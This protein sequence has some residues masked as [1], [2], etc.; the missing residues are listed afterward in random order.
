VKPKLVIAI[1]IDQFR[2]D[3]LTRFRADYHNGIDQLLT[4]G[5][6]FTSAYYGQVPT[7]TAVG[8]SIFMS[9]AMPAVSG[10]VGNSWYD[11]ETHQIVTS[12]CDWNMKVVGAPQAEKKSGCTD[13]DP[14]SPARLLVST[15][16]DELRLAHP[17]AKVIGISRKARAAILPSGHAANGAFWFDDG[18]GNFITSSFYMDKLPP[19]VEAFNARKLPEK[20]VDRPWPNFPNW[21]FRAGS[22]SKA[23]YS[24][25]DASPWSNELIEA[26]AEQAITGEK[27]GQRGETDLLTVSFSANDA[28]GHSVGPYAPEVKDMAIR[29]DQLIGKLFALLEQK[30]GMQNVI[31]VLSADHGVAPTPQQNAVDKIPGGYLTG[32]VETTITKALSE[33]FGNQRWLLNGSSESVYF[34]NDAIRNPKVRREDV[35]ETARDAL[36]NNPELHIVRVYS[37]SQLEN[38]VAGDFIAQAEMNGFFPRRSGDLFLVFDPGYMAGAH[39]TSHFSP[40][41]YDRHVP[42]VFMGPVIRAGRYSADARP[43]DIAP[44]LADI[45]DLQVPSG[46]SGRVLTEMLQREK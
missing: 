14:A 20:Y 25:L 39:G 21:K 8:H 31:V 13:D 36:L 34:N 18:T 15:L 45:L 41:N 16:G 27:L 43:N 12:V 38:G 9:G 22:G 5:A 1:I 23:T 32:G 3:Y 19:W 2:Y 11:R 10:I 42:V 37:R 4:R 28:V 44:T 6:D 33:R 26:L 24:K 35:F 7:V 29:T 30:V 40:Y 17:N 46:S